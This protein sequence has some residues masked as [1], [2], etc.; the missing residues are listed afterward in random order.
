M[1][2]TV[3]IRGIEFDR[4]EVLEALSASGDAGTVWIHDKDW[5]EG[6][7]RRA[8]EFQFRPEDVTAEEWAFMREW[9]LR[10]IQLMRE[11]DQE[12]LAESGSPDQ[13]QKGTGPERSGS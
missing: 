9:Y 12:I 2:H 5:L 10:T 4:S 8:A 6:A 7:K 1:K 13:D 3:T 11:S